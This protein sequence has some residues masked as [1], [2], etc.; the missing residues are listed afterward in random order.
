MRKDDIPKLKYLLPTADFPYFLHMQG[1]IGYF[2]ATLALFF[3]HGSYFR[4]VRSLYCLAE[5]TRKHPQRLVKHLSN[6]HNLTSSF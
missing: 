6:Q 1:G 2:R 4:S 5:I 3:Y